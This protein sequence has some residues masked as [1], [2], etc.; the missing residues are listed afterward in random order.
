MSH[1][2]HRGAA[3]SF[4]TGEK[5][6]DGTN[7]K[8]PVKYKLGVAL[9]GGGARGFAH[10]GALMAI[11]EAG[12]KPDIIAGV[13]AGSVVAVLY[14]AG[15]SP[16]N[17]PSIFSDA[18]FRDFAE[19]SMGGGGLFGINRF[20][21][22]ILSHLGGARKLEDLK[23][24]TYIGVTDF[25]HGEPV[26]FHTGDIGPRMTASCSIPIVF[27]PVKIDGVN[28]V[29]GGVL[30]NMPAWI[31]RDKCEILI[32][33]NVSP[34]RRMAKPESIIGVTLRTYNLMAKA[35]QAIDMAMCDVAIET[36]EI[37]NYKVF[38]LSN[39]QKV[40]VSGY[41]HARRALRDAGLWNPSGNSTDHLSDLTAKPLDQ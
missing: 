31:I 39:I 37:S 27:K 14:A 21:K 1:T 30:R 2:K 16:L 3:A 4:P 15:V 23:I 34:L 12:L 19:F 40:F 29:D 18:G 8:Q 10:A 11:E 41:M 26:E 38:D 32:G 33:V 13:S 5:P 20:Q 22:F 6:Q 17:I 25:D 7:T 35:N 36:P 28:Y 9:S 24:P